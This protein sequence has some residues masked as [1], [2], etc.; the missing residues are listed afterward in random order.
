MSVISFSRC[1]RSMIQFHARNC[2]KIKGLSGL[3][4]FARYN[5]AVHAG[6][7]PCRFCKP[8]QRMDVAASVPIYNQER[9]NESVVDMTKR[10]EAYGFTCE[11]EERVV[12]IIT[13]VARWSFDP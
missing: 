6:F 13:P 12:T 10:C 9:A 3:R 4:G 8:T 11:V 1:R 5:E 2:G 7:K